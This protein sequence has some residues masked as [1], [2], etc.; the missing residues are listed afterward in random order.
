ME[1]ADAGNQAMWYRMFMEE[2]GYEANDPIMLHGNNQGSINLSLNPSTRRKSKHIPIKYH[3]IRDYV[4]DEH[5]E[6][7]RT[8]TLDMLADGLTKPLGQNKLEDFVVGLGLV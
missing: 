1:V 5:I 3:V 2:L 7:I 4:E 8:S 6:L